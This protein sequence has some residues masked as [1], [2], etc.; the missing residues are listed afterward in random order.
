MYTVSEN[1]PGCGKCTNRGVCP[2]GAIKI[3]NNKAII[4][5]ECID[6][7]LCIPVCPIN[8]IIKNDINEVVQEVSINI[9]T[10]EE[11]NHE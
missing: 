5:Q 8:V 6:C 3:K 1:C 4:G 2:T 7:G 11:D 9:E 10:R